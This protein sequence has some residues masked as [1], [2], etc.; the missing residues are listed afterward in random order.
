MAG[1][2]EVGPARAKRNLAM[3]GRRSLGDGRCGGV[4]H[5]EDY[6]FR[7]RAAEE[8]DVSHLAVDC[9][10]QATDVETDE[11]NHLRRRGGSLGDE[12]A[13]DPTGQVGG[14]LLLNKGGT[15]RQLGPGNGGY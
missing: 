15:M 14:R 10:A 5:S 13:P 12:R 9:G 8:P 1:L 11:K 4:V 6:L 2:K 3:D 7:N